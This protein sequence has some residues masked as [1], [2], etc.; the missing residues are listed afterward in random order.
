MAMRVVGAHQPPRTPDQRPGRGARGSQTPDVSTG[1]SP[2]YVP[3]DPAPPAGGAAVLD[4]GGW[5]DLAVN[6][7]GIGI[8][9]E[10]PHRQ[11]RDGADRSRRVGADGEPEAAA[12]LATLTAVSRWDRWRGGRQ[13][14]FVLHSVPLG[15]GH[16]NTRGIDHVVVGARL[17]WC[18]STPSI[19]APAS[20]SSMVT[21]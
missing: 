4:G 5:R 20:L 15:D 11:Q 21:S 14:W 16:G 10:A 18:R 17:R 6:P 19:T 1:R 2:A 9:H 3:A 7:P 8:T 13:E 12:L